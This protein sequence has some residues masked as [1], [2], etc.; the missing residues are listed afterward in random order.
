MPGT[1]KNACNPRPGEILLSLDPRHLKLVKAVLAE[2]A[3]KAEVWAYGSRVSG[4]CHDGSDLDLVVRN[5]G[6][7]ERP[8]MAAG[9]KEAFSESDVPFLVD[10]L[11]WDD[12]PPTF[13]AE[14]LKRHEVVQV[15]GNS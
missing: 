4:N 13:H 11:D 15:P 12:I 5:P 1:W 2:H 3:P 14:I 9:L 6:D 8:L 7:P 10:V